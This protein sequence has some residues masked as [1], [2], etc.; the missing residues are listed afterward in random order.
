MRKELDEIEAERNRI[1]RL[2][3]HPK[4]ENAIRKKIVQGGNTTEIGEMEG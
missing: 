2:Q 3:E 1:L 4:R